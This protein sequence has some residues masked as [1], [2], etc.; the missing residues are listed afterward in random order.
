MDDLRQRAATWH[1]PAMVCAAVMAVM[2]VVSLGGLVLDDRVLLGAPIWLK[3]F[4]F[5]VSIALYLV[6][7]AWM[8][9]LLEKGKRLA[10][11]VSLGLVIAVSV[12][13]VIIVVQ[14]V[15]GQTSHFNG[16]TPLNATL[17]AIMG[18]T[19][20]A[21][22]VGTF[23]LTVLL[24]LTPL[25][26]KA[27]QWGIRLGA[28][29]ALAGLG[30]AF[31]MTSPTAMQ[32]AAMKTDTFDGVVGAHSVGVADGG[33]GMAVT[34]WSTTGGD[35]RIPHFVGMHALQALPLFVLLLGV[36]AARFPRLRDDTLRTRLVVIA[37]AGYAGIV[38][39][40]TWQALRAQSLI[41][42]DAP[43]LGAFAALVVLLAVSTVLVL[44]RRELVAAA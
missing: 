35:L 38:A 2:A 4:K 24:F 25:K 31:L 33:P 27:S 23:V 28:V 30:L 11:H 18:V 37:A 42:P 32:L 17:Y 6:T 21:L 8:V 41:H 36:L 39:L 3:P 10:R 7:W 14:V 26:D 22:W 40:V 15:R 43:T 12:E 34:G 5:A 13:Y 20:S 29:I 44:R 19:I 16:T 9:S 1:R